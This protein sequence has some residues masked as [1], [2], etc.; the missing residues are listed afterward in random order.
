MRHILQIENLANIYNNR[1]IFWNYQADTDI[2][3]FVSLDT[4]YITW[5][6]QRVLKKCQKKTTD[7]HHNHDA[8]MTT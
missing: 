1:Q 3:V 4:K 2:Y 5:K 7:N 8:T 6:E